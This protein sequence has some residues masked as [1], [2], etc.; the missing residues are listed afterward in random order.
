M[1]RYDWGWDR[2]YSRPDWPPYDRM[3]R[4]GDAARGA[5]PRSY[6]WPEHG[7]RGYGGY[8]AR[9]GYDYGGYGGRS[10]YRRRDPRPGERYDRGYRYSY[11]GSPTGGRGP[12]GRQEPW[13]P[14]PPSG[15]GSEWGRVY[16]NP[17]PRLEHRVG[18]WDYG[19][20]RPRR[21]RYDAPPWTELS[22]GWASYTEEWD[23]PPGYVD[24]GIED[25]FDEEDDE[26]YDPFEFDDDYQEP[27]AAEPNDDDVRE[28]VIQSLQS[29]G[30]LNA[31]AIQVEVSDRVVT[32]RGEVSDFMEARYAWDDAWDAPGVRGVISKITVPGTERQEAPPGAARKAGSATPPQPKSATKKGQKTKKKPSPRSP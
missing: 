15:Y 11:P 16:G 26:E 27:W 12:Y 32:L 22:G 14:G 20:G 18:A 4:S 13:E 19:E 23:L 8:D 1:H 2:P 17:P 31:D 7:R 9:G 28:R 5:T 29:D 30:F 25:F 24:E 6:S 3:Y 10:E 21:G